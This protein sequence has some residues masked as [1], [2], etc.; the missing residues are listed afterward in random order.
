MEKLSLSKPFKLNDDRIITEL[1]LLFDELSVADF[2]QIRQLES[3]ITDNKIVV[4]ESMVKPKNFSFEFQLASGFLA[5]VKG[6]NGMR[7]ND[8]TRLPMTD[9][10]S[11]ARTASFFLA[12]CG[13]KQTFDIV[14]LH[15]VIGQLAI[16]YHTDIVR[17]L[18]MPIVSLYYH[19]LLEPV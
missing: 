18:E 13:L 1:S 2:R 15:G 7:I 5:A 8:F 6:T 10:I 14:R 12:R 16:Q 3:Q 19:F 11:L 9:A 4:T 17:L